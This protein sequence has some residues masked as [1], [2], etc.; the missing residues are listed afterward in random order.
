MVVG[1]ST[2]F[3]THVR[4]RSTIPDLLAELLPSLVG[5]P[6]E[7]LNLGRALRGPDSAPAA[8]AAGCS[9]CSAR[10]STNRCSYS[11]GTPHAMT[12][13]ALLL[14]VIARRLSCSGGR[15]GMKRIV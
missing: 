11:S 8:A 10:G 5:G 15:S 14:N 6:W 4:E 3:G 2:I 9:G 1:D 7:A 13:V 12:V